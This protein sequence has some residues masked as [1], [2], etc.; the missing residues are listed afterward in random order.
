LPPSADIFKLPKQYFETRHIR[1]GNSRVL[2]RGKRSS[3]MTE[4]DLAQTHMIPNEMRRD[5]GVGN[6]PYVRGRVR[7]VSMLNS[8]CMVMQIRKKHA[9]DAYHS[10]HKRWIPFDEFLKASQI[11]T[12]GCIPYVTHVFTLQQRR[13]VLQVRQK[14]TYSLPFIFHSALSSQNTKRERISTVPHASLSLGSRIH[15]HSVHTSADE[16]RNKSL[17]KK[18]RKTEWVGHE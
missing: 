18:R 9:M 5:D 12:L 2:I 1:T 10:F 15:N 16:T 13:R 14:H 17:A 3:K 4:E 6:T 11:S 7:T 8:R